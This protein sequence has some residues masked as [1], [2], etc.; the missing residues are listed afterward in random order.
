MRKS[1][2]LQTLAFFVVLAIGLGVAWVAASPPFFY[3]SGWIVVIAVAVAAIAAASI[4]VAD[5]W[6]RVIVLRLGKF[7]SL[8]GP[9][10]FFII[11]IFETVPYW[12]DVRVITS[13][14][15]AEKTLTKDTVPVD[16]DAVLFWKVIDPKKA[17]LDVADYNGAINWAA[18]TALRD[19]IGKTVLADM[20]EGR[21][22]IS[23][24]LQKIIDVRT[25]PWG[26]QRHLGR[27]E[28]RADPA[29][30]AGRDVD[31]GAGRART[32]GARHP[33]RFRAPGGGEVRRG[34]EDLRQQ[35]DRLPSAR[36]EHALRGPEARQRDDRHRAE[37]RG[38]YDAARRDD[39]EPEH[40]G[41]RNGQSC[42]APV[43][44]GV[45]GSSGKS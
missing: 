11:P 8:E 28:R 44:G 39:C 40:D 7:R 16:V 25:E 6:L 34:G 24:E 31:A 26:D 15:K 23:A 43:P 2:S 35:P 30:A 20:L 18:Q 10:L 45:N 3:A 13:T 4:R 12:I 22:K 38:R 21:D 17:A 37:H 5:Q 14:F 42:F 19:V 41:R 33:R 1:S 9:G 27:G 29:G 36:D 32:P